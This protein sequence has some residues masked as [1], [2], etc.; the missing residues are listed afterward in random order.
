M[1]SIN[2]YLNFAGNTEEAFKFYQ[3]LSKSLSAKSKGKLLQIFIKWLKLKNQN[4]N[5]HS[6]LKET[7]ITYI[8]SYF[9][10]LLTL[11]IKSQLCNFDCNYNC[12]VVDK[13]NL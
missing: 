2:P 8:L 10:F 5:L 9:Q 12:S 13:V 7:N 1:P 4:Q 6:S 3:L 11:V